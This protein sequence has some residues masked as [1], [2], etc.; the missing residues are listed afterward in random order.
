VRGFFNTYYLAVM[1]TAGAATVSYAVVGRFGFA[2]GA[3]ALALLAIVLRRTLL[4]MMDRLR[5]RIQ[6]GDAGAIVR[7][8]RLHV[9]AILVNTM[10]LA[11][12]VWTLIA[13][14]MK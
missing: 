12:I 1:F 14:S 3:A 10:Q 8:R 13:F 6:E 4:P 2:A 11:L 9:F 5:V 7:F